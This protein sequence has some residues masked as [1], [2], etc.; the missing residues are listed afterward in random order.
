ML[1][2]TRNGDCIFH[3]DLTGTLDFDD[4]AK[5]TDRRKII[6]GLLFSLKSYLK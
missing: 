5:I 2:F 3:L 4:T 6:F 1:I